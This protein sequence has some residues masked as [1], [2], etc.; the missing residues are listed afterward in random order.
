[1]LHFNSTLMCKFIVLYF[2]FYLCHEHCHNYSQI[3]FVLMLGHNTILAILM[4]LYP[5]TIIKNGRIVI[6]YYLHGSEVETAAGCVD[7]L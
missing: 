7:Q 6:C 1:M 2:Y 4:Y 3:H 5:Y